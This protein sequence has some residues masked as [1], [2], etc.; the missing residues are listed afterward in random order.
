M[1]ALKQERADPVIQAAVSQ[2]IKK[3]PGIDLITLVKQ[4]GMAFSA[5][6]PSDVIDSM[7]DHDKL[8]LAKQCG[9]TFQSGL[10]ASM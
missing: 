4:I 2:L 5:A 10:Q 1:I 6:L 9:M 7:S 3:N 8:S